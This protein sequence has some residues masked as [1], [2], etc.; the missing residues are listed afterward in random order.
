MNR[1]Q[2]ETRQESAAQQ[3]LSW[4]LLVLSIALE[5]FEVIEFSPAL[6]LSLF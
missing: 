1:H 2:S 5:A 6:P 4:L 3:Q